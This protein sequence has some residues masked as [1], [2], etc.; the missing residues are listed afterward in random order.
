MLSISRRKFTQSL[1]ALAASH[2]ALA[3][4]AFAQT[5]D[6]SGGVKPRRID[7]HHHILPPE[8]VATVGEKA[9]GAP[10]PNREIPKWDVSKSIEAMDR[11]G[12][13]SAVVSVSAPGILLDDPGKTSRLARACNQ[14]AAQMVADHPA[15]YGMFASLP[16]PDT[17]ASLLEL[18]YALDVLH[19]EGIV[20]MTNYRD[21]YLG[22]PDFAPIFDEMNR[23]KAVV[24]VHPTTCGCNVEVLPDNPAALIE[25]P[26]D[27]TRTITSLLFSGTYSRCP[28]IRFIFSHAGGT[29]PFLADRIARIAS[30]DRRL[31]AQTPDGVMPAFKRLYYDTAT[32]ANPMSF[33]ALMQLVTPRSVL[34]GTDFPFIPEP[35]MKATI[36]GLRQVG[37]DEAAVRAIEGENA[38]ALFPRLGAMA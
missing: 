17:R 16:M 5:Q 13:T 11:N 20:L 30:Q 26:H 19:A 37:L 4:L 28:D 25:F 15:R 29:L 34:L 6:S 12:I 31:A 23:R 24:Y 27:S 7:V 22:D 21:R 18:N 35:G 33:G 3:Q 10:A 38:A 2:C 14:F 36:A 9:I 1:T 8:Y 32:S